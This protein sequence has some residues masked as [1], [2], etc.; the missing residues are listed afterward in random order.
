MVT[1]PK[2]IER[3]VACKKDNNVN[4]Q[5]FCRKKPLN[6]SQ[7]PFVRCIPYFDTQ[8]ATVTLAR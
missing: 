6:L 2:H 1:E 4:R 7:G 8:G 5:L 3:T